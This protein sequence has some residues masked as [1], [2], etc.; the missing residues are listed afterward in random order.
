VHDNYESI[1][2]IGFAQ[3]GLSAFSGPGHW[4]D[5]DMLEIGNG[6]LSADENRTQ[7]SLWSTL[8]APLLAGN[9]VSHM[10][11]DDLTILTN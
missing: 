2:G 10:T 8:A 9:D 4:N 7:M 5:P 6:K 3:A 11:A 1:T